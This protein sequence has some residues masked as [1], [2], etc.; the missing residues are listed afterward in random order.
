MIL[1]LG[2]FLLAALEANSPMNA[3][4]FLKKKSQD[5]A[6][7]EGRVFVSFTSSND[8]EKRLFFTSF[9]MPG[10]S[11]IGSGLRL[12]FFSLCNCNK[13]V[14]SESTRATID[15][16]KLIDPQRMS[17]HNLERLTSSSKINC[18]QGHPAKNLGNSLLE[19]ELVN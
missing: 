12:T 3:W 13:M 9:A 2:F 6:T 10:I 5:K 15:S 7:G 11:N 14:H 1:M 4:R 18:L 8:P 16:V 17:K 19:R